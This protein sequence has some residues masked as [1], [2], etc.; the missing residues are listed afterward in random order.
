LAIA[1]QR[2]LF[3]ANAVFSGSSLLFRNANEQYCHTSIRQIGA[4]LSAHGSW[5]IAPGPACRGLS[6]ESEL[7]DL[8]MPMR[9]ARDG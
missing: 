8:D 2:G 9:D 6:V 5:R 7:A 3:P 1:Q 4:W